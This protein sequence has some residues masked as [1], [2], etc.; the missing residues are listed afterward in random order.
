M[1]A[2]RIDKVTSGAVVFAKTAEAHA[3]LARQFNR[4]SIEKAYLAIVRGRRRAARTARSTCPCRSG[5]R[6]GCAWRR[7]RSSIVVDERAPVVVGGAV[8]RLRR[9]AD[10]SRPAPTSA[11]H[12]R[13][14]DATLLVAE[15]VTG[16]RH[17]IRVHLGVD[18]LAHPGRSALRRRARRADVPPRAGRS[19]ST[20]RGPT[21]GASS[22][23]RRRRP[24]F[25]APLGGE[26]PD[27]PCWPPP[28]R[29]GHG[30]GRPAAN[31]DRLGGRHPQGPV[32]ERGVAQAAAQLP[33]Q[34]GDRVQV[35]RRPGVLVGLA[36][37]AGQHR[38]R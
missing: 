7:A 25:W 20:P 10:V 27:A 32:Q 34:P 14:G 1:P 17:Q 23:R 12:E 9:Q 28:A 38:R 30:S 3:A 31:R 22:W 18:R 33:L 29:R 24:D 21:G 5:A 35:L 15:P 19:P 16:R 2:H 11:R 13:A 6:T 36:G 26:T 8:G 4:R 37:V